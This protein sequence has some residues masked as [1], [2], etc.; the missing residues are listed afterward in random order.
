MACCGATFDENSVPPWTRGDFQGGLGHN[1]Q[2]GVGCPPGNP[3]RR[4]ATA[5]SLLK[6]PPSRHPSDG[7]DFQDTPVEAGLLYGRR[8]SRMFTLLQGCLPGYARGSQFWTGSRDYQ[9]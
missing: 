6:T 8:T 3:P 2:A 1:S 4:S 7:G 5:W 9:L